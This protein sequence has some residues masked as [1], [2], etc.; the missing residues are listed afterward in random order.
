MADAPARKAQ[1]TTNQLDA[2]HK[3]FNFCLNCRQYTCGN[4]WNT[5]EGRCL[6][7]VPLPGMEKDAQLLV[8]PAIAFAP[9]GNGAHVHDGVAAEPG[10]DGWPEVD[11]GPEAW[12]EADVGVERVGAAMGV[13]ALAEDD[14]AEAEAFLEAA[15]DVEVEAPTLEAWPT[16][17]ELAAAEAEARAEAD[18]GDEFVMLDDAAV[19]A[20]INGVA[21]GQSVEDAV[22]AYEAQLAAEEEQQRHAALAAAALVSAVDAEPEPETVAEVLPSRRRSP[23][24]RR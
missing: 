10:V 12:P 19:E 23:S 24:R 6:T 9:N 18:A 17:E 20:R 5:A 4:C 11:L 14:E 16:D 3:T 7:C 21:P 8:V 2:F 1:R 13:A 15:P 22:A